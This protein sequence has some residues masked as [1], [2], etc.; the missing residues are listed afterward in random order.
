MSIHQLAAALGEL[1]QAIARSVP[2]G[3]CAALLQVMAACVSLLVQLSRSLRTSEDPRVAAAHARLIETLFRYSLREQL[4]SAIHLESTAAHLLADDDLAAVGSGTT[5]F[6]QPATLHAGRAHYRGSNGFLASWLGLDFHEADRRVQD[7]H[8]LIARRAMDGSTIAPRFSALAQL[9]TDSPVLDPRSVARAARALDKFEP[10]DT[11]FEGQPLQ[12]TATHADGRTLEEHVVELFQDRDLTTAQSLVSDLISAERLAR[13]TVKTPQ[14]GFFRRAS[15]GECD[16]YEVIVTGAQREEF[17]SFIGQ[18]DNPRTEAGKSARGAQ[19]NSFQ[20]NGTTGAGPVANDL[21]SS[22]EP[23]PPWAQEPASEPPQAD[24][25]SLS[26]AEGQDQG[27]VGEQLAADSQSAAGS[28][29]VPGDAVPGDADLPVPQRRLNALIAALK[30]RG[31]RGSAK[32]ATPKIA[33]HVQLD[34]LA[35][36]AAPEQLSSMSEHG[37]KLGPADTSALICQGE[38]YRVVFG[39]DGQPL[40]VGRSQRF[41]TEAM[42][43]AIFARD[44]GCI[45]PGC[46]APPEML[47][48]HHNDWWEHGGCTSVRN[49]SCLCRAHHHAIHAQLLNLVTVSGLAHIVLPKHLDPLQRPQRNRI[50][51]AYS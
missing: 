22:N 40:D 12:P 31:G 17:R 46:T 2:R 14:P 10:A 35:D 24:E 38:I 11:A 45:V 5:D 41:F 51:L 44:R 49:G 3:T 6:S 29:Q 18:S 26:D 33:I 37:I 4:H 13:K 43:R 9:F 30:N 34:S 28:E 32:T 42:K 25:N 16:R 20:D 48:Y 47:E 50:H 21:F 1:Q 19:G 8:L 36:L 23:M 27:L 15:I 39:P 7:A